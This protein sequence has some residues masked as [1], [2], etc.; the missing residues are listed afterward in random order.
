MTNRYTTFS[1]EL[2]PYATDLLNAV[3]V[4]QETVPA[5][6]I[7]WALEGFLVVYRPADWVPPAEPED[8]PSLC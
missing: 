1:V 4:D 3:A 8:T 5:E 2:G 6:I 7:R